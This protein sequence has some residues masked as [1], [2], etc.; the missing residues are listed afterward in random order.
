MHDR[1]ECLFAARRGFALDDENLKTI[2]ARIAQDGRPK[3][4]K[5]GSPAPIQREVS[6]QEIAR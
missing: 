5:M 2:M 6:A 3:G 4:G 1:G